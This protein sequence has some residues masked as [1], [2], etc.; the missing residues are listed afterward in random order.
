MILFSSV[1]LT[2]ASS[3]SPPPLSLSLSL[4]LSLF[5]F[6][7][8]L[9]FLS[10]SVAGLVVRK[11]SPRQRENLWPGEFSEKEIKRNLLVGDF[12][13]L[14]DLS[15]NGGRDIFINKRLHTARFRFGRCRN[16]IGVRSRGSF[17]PVQSCRRG[18][19]RFYFDD[20]PQLATERS[21]VSSLY[22]AAPSSNWD[23]VNL[24]AQSSSRG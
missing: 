17:R 7:Y 21:A 3:F 22:G 19:S 16:L 1:A 15:P 14:T 5:M 18:K 23:Y 8:I 12:R 6:L 13:P 11:V 24:R 2:I 10:N 9:S 20:R 4:S